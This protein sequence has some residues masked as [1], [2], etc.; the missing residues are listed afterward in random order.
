MVKIVHEHNGKRV[1]G[2]S[3]PHGTGMF[4]LTNKKGSFLSLSSPSISQYNGLIV[5]DSENECLFK[6][7]DMLA[8]RGIPTTVVNRVS[9]VERQYKD[10]TSERY[11]LSSQAMHYHFTGNGEIIVDMDMRRLNDFDTRGRT[12]LASINGDEVTIHYRKFTDDTQQHLAYERFLVIKGAGKF[13]AQG[14]WVEKQVPY[15]RRRGEKENLWV[16]RAGMIP[17]VGGANLVVTSS[18]TL[19]MALEKARS[20]FEREDEILESNEAYVKKAYNLERLEENL[21]LA[22]LDS[23]VT[24]L[25]NATYTGIWAGLPWFTQ[26][27]SRDEL[28]SLGAL[29]KQGQYGLAKEIITRYCELLD[30]P[31]LHAHYP[32][33]GALSADALGWLAKRTHDLLLTLEEEKHLD[34]YFTKLELGYFRERFSKALLKLLD[35]H[36]DAGLIVNGPGETWMDAIYQDD[37]R[38]GARIEIQALTLCVYQ[39]LV[40][41]EKKSRKLP[42]KLLGLTSWQKKEQL[43]AERVKERF[44]HRGKLFD[45]IVD[46]QEDTT[47]RP[48]IFLVHYLYPQLLSNEEWI[49]VFDDAL[50]HLWLPWG[51]LASIE[52]KDP[53]FMHSY[54]GADDKSYHR[55]DSWYWINAI[56]ALSL[57]R[58][59]KKKYGKKIS[60]IV[61]ASLK[62]MLFMGAIGHASELSS[63][64]QMEWGGTYAQAWSAALLLEFLLE[65]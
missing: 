54:S 59:D 37:D 21:A 55:G 44:F 27:W 8:H 7:V 17:V 10:E 35:E 30:E 43:Y 11:W 15:D 6:T 38:H 32:M 4:L 64:R 25:K 29:V 58:V 47:S 16:Y 14:T 36:T 19:E 61:E 63:A 53:L 34:E 1:E 24:K 18:N 3:Q 48:N 9:H 56:A 33:G 22:S 50:G 46:G 13:D 65:H 51:G 62:D 41:L 45:G 40:Y 28:I 39:L 42:L 60:S 12:Y 23:M 20:V 2:E 31:V 26:F 52:Q 5:Y 49:A 57:L